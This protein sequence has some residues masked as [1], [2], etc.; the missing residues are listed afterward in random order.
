MAIDGRNIAS[1]P[2]QKR[3]REVYES[4][5]L[6]VAAALIV[7]VPLAA[8][9]AFAYWSGTWFGGTTGGV[10]SVLSTLATVAVLWMLRRRRR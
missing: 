10:L 9:V 5:G 2:P 6:K 4:T 7:V 8:V 3:D 1:P